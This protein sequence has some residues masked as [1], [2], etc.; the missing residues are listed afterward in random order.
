MERGHRLVF[1]RL[2]RERALPLAP[3]ADTAGRLE[4]RA[5]TSSTPDLGDVLA[6]PLRGQGGLVFWSYLGLLLVRLVT[7]RIPGL[8]TVGGVVM[9]AVGLLVPGLLFAIIRKTASGD[10][11]LPD[12]P[13]L[14]EY[15]ERAREVVSFLGAIL[16]LSLPAYLVLLALHCDVSAV[17]LSTGSTSR[18]CD[19]AFAAGLLPGAL[20]AV[21]MF[22][23]L[24]IFES[25]WTL[26]RLDLHA[27]AMAVLGGDGLRTAGSIYA[28]Q[29]AGSILSA[30]LGQTPW[31]GGVLR[32]VVGAYASFVSAYLVGLVFRRHERALDAI[33]MA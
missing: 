10:D 32:T 1:C 11:E 9:C 17:V 31:L 2:C 27:R 16:V 8:G 19:L 12:W 4:P 29:L 15:S 7:S 13:D 21:P 20:L 26:I 33:Y 6:Y 25:M 22:G 24:A 30:A 23:S 14:T 5:A 3:A 28:L 18:A